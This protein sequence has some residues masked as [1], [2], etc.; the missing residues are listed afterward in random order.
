MLR[1]AG[2]YTSQAHLRGAVFTRESARKLQEERLRTLRER[3][4]Q[5]ILRIT[6]SEGRTTTNPEDIVAEKEYLAAQQALV[7]KLASVQATGRVVVKMLP[8]GDM[9]ASAWD[10]V[11]EDGDALTIPTKPQTVAVVG[12]VYNPTSLLWEPDN[13]KVEH[14]LDKTGGPTEDAETNGVYV[15][16]ADGTVVS[17]DSASG[18]NWWG[19]E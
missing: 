16:L 12:E 15:V 1:R 11:L 4:E 19:G 10:I 2:G 17:P 18:G 3:L 9:E 5:T 13:K 7:A 6:A 14:Y 8:L